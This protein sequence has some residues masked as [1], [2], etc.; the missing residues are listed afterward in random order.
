MGREPQTTQQH[1]ASTSPEYEQKKTDLLVISHDRQL[2]K[3]KSRLLSK[4]ITRHIEHGTAASQ[5]R[6]STKS[7]VLVSRPLVRKYG[8]TGANC[9][10]QTGWSYYGLRMKATGADINNQLFHFSRMAQ[11]SVQTTCIARSATTALTSSAIHL[12]DPYLQNFVLFLHIRRRTTHC[13]GR[14]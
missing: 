5:R 3:H 8:Y 7:P 1:R 14:T 2:N 6:N 4:E 12:F 13:P 10:K 9:L 11:S